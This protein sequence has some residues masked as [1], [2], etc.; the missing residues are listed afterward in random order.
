MKDENDSNTMRL[1]SNGIT[2]SYVFYTAS[3]KI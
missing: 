3:W 2:R 1:D